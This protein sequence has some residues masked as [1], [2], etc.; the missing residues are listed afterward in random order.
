MQP[1]AWQL[2]L[3]PG[4]CKRHMPSSPPADLIPISNQSLNQQHRGF[5]GCTTKEQL[6][7][8]SEKLNLQGAKPYNMKEPLIEMLLEL[9]GPTNK[10][11]QQDKQ[12]QCTLCPGTSPCLWHRQGKFKGC[13][14][15]GE[16]FTADWAVT[17]PVSQR[18]FVLA[19]IMLVV[20]RSREGCRTGFGAFVEVWKINRVCHQSVSPDYF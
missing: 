19:T 5:P 13:T 16:D 18:L 10:M 12:G 2:E 9:A 11:Y 8:M 6:G 17:S 20:G 7:T 1:H 15:Q 4:S 3:S 14:L